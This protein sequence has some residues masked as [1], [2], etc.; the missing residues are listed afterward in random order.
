MTAFI[1]MSETLIQRNSQ[2]SPDG[3]KYTYL[4]DLQ[5]STASHNNNQWEASRSETFSLI[6]TH[7]TPCSSKITFSSS[8]SPRL[9]L[10]S[11]VHESLPTLGDGRV[12]MDVEAGG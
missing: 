4:Q 6:S 5:T 12:F 9:P 2:L 3:L 11:I 7:V 8:S 1:P 10:Y